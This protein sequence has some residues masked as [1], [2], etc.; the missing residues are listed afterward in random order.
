MFLLRKNVRNGKRNPLTVLF[1]RTPCSQHYPTTDRNT[2]LH[3]FSA[4]LSHVDLQQQHTMASGIWM[5]KNLSH[6][7]VLCLND[8]Q[9]N[10]CTNL[11]G[12]TPYSEFRQLSQKMNTAFPGKGNKH[13]ISES[14]LSQ[15][16]PAREHKWRPISIQ[17]QIMIAPGKP[18]S[19]GGF[20]AHLEGIS[21]VPEISLAS[22]HGL[23]SAALGCASNLLVPF[24]LL[25]PSQHWLRCSSAD[26][27]V[28]CSGFCSFCLWHLNSTAPSSSVLTYW[29]SDLC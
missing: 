25:S 22:P 26:L 10:L 6:I 5:E 9:K 28:S 17:A 16:W 18:H 23:V 15:E 7:W 2:E 8:H 27:A 14:Q 21:Q 19:P 4:Q 29:G 1:P 13:D 12:C 3:S 24:G 20:W 11:S